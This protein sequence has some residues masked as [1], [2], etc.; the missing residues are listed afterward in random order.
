[1]ATGR[2]PLD[3]LLPSRLGW[4]VVQLLVA[5]ALLMLWRGRRF[6]RLVPEPLPVSVRVSETVE[7]LGRLYR[8]ARSRRR[9]ADALRHAARTRMAPRLGLRR[10]DP[11]TAVVEAVAVRTGRPAA[12]VAALLYGAEPGDDPALVALAAQL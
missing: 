3:K 9:A 4:A 11:P 12:D 7:G 10:D 5:I 6:G 1:A 2:T 8:A